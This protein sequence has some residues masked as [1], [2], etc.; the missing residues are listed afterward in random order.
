MNAADLNQPST[1]ARELDHAAHCRLRFRGDFEV[2]IGTGVSCHVRVPHL[3]GV[4]SEHAALRRVG[5]R[6]FIKDLSSEGGTFVNGRRLHPGCWHELCTGDVVAVSDAIVELGRG[7]F[8]GRERL[9]LESTLLT[10]VLPGS[11][12]VVCNRVHVRARPG[13]VTAILGP[14]GSGKTTLLSILSGSL[15]PTEG[16]VFLGTRYDVHTDHERV[17]EVLGCVP[18]GD[19]M[20]PELTL[21]Q[22]LEYRLRLRFPDMAPQVRA[23]VVR[24]TCL[25]L[26]FEEA[27]LDDLLDTPIG[28]A[29]SSGGLS[30][31][32][33]KRANIAMELVTRPVVLLLDEPTSGL[34]STEAEQ[35]VRLL[36]KLA[37]EDDLTIVLTVHQPSRDVFA[38]FDD[39]LL[40]SPE[41][42][43]AYY[44][45]ARDA[46]THFEVLT[47]I[48]C[49]ERNPAD[50][51]VWVTAELRSGSPALLPGAGA[52]PSRFDPLPALM[53]ARGERPARQRSWVTN[54]ASAARQWF[55]LF[56]RDV[57]VLRADGSN[58]GL[59]LVQAP[60]IA[61]LVLLAFH[62]FERDVRRDDHFARAGYYFS[63]AA[64]PL[65]REGKTVVADAL[66]NAAAAK[67]PG[68]KRMVSE[69]HACKRA[70]AYFVLA[71]ASIWFG[72]IGA[73]KAVV[74]EQHIV[75]RESRAGVRLG[76]YL[77]AKGVTLAL[78]VGVQ[79]GLV[80]GIVAPLL[81]GASLRCTLMLWTA[82]WVAGAAA[83]A[84][85]LLVSCAAHTTRLALTAVPLLLVPQLLL[86]GLL[87]Y[88]TDL[89]QAS[90]ILGA[91]SDLTLQRWAFEGALAADV[92][93]RGGV[94]RQVLSD[95]LDTGRP[96]AEVR[97]AQFRN[98]PITAVFF[99]GL[100]Q[101]APALPLACLGLEAGVFF[102]AAYAVLSWRLA[103]CPGAR[104]KEVVV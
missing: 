8:A 104:R 22:S 14:C 84:L 102:V 93:A 46:A 66:W 56:Q 67:A 9:S 78:L 71:A 5:D 88:R 64:E 91:M 54:L 87:R 25:R 103:V 17:R 82:L 90:P 73:C 42:T 2:L 13:T 3:P 47:G 50:Y 95:R 51:L 34:S 48:Q 32:E 76:P 1:K 21:R 99:P 74:A 69:R 72:L 61:L 63:T 15:S 101:A 20:F 77:G 92:Y 6:V 98:V 10:Y 96:Y 94:L 57:R 41:G 62:R 36:H 68:D 19:L 60:L 16:R 44:G 24:D 29:D 53:R 85:G 12:R 80:A 52:S 27:R 33:R 75:R 45:V 58:L 7:V 43:A 49:G 11:Q 59:A 37:R 89:G 100:P 70:A 30:G 55:V 65:V 4:A 40:L 18:Q 39:L 86:G 79:T 97:L 23:R 28:S 31:G 38:L 26:G 83:V 81:L 35:V